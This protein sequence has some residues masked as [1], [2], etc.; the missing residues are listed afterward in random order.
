MAR[1]FMF[2]YRRLA[3]S[4]L[5]ACS[6][7][8]PAPAQEPRTP[9]WHLVDLLWKLPGE[10]KL[11]FKSYSMD[12]EI[13]SDVPESSSLF[14]APIGLGSLGDATFYAGIQVSPVPMC[15][16]LQGGR[17]GIFSSW[18]TLDA[19][20]KRVEADGCSEM[21]TYENNALSVRRPLRW[22]QGKFTVSLVLIETDPVGRRW[23]ALAVKDLQSGQITRI[24]SLR[25]PAGDYDFSRAMMSFVEIFNYPTTTNQIPA[26]TITFRNPRLNGE[27][28][29][30]LY[31]I[32][33]FPVNV[34]SNAEV[35]SPTPGVLA[36]TIGGSKERAGMQRTPSG[37][38]QQSFPW[39]KAPEEGCG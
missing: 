2:S 7:I 9:V 39:G 20:D 17:R 16:G 22:K 21:V 3:Y 35:A 30:P 11:N 36:I 37:G 5:L 25:F 34:P 1:Y 4:V 33:C 26:T 13:S 6:F 14:I 23:V 32:A 19:G 10:G 27:T 15:P 31:A 29:K 24:G 18:K 28:L 38:W 12:I 8:S